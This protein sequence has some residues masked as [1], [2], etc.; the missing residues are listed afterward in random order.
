MKSV[1]LGEQIDLV[2]QD[3][4]RREQAGDISPN[5]LRAIENSYR[6][7]KDYWGQ[8]STKEVTKEKWDEFQDWF[9]KL[10]PNGSHFNS[11]K[12]FTVLIGKLHE[13]GF[14][15]QKIL[16][17]DRFARRE[18]NQRRKKK[19]WVF[20]S[21]EIKALDDACIDLKERAQLRL[22]YLMGFRISDV[23]QLTWDRIILTGKHAYVEFNG[24]D[25]KAGTIARCPLPPDLLEMILELPKN[26]KWVFPQSRNSDRHIKT[27]Q[28]D[29]LAIRRRSGVVRG[30]FHSL[31]HFCLSRD[32]KN[33]KLTT[34]QVCKMRRVSLAVA[35]EHYVHVSDDDMGLM[36]EET[37]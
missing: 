3:Y 34:A 15:K 4:R 23:C 10:N 21:E 17:K 35:H 1:N 36:I 29:F 5:S 25:D 24:S 26:S 13:Q 14:L 27:Q 2:I 28:I 32:F 19:N 11:K 37:K 9:E 30:T 16:V 18:K 12:Y 33:P 20:T 8:L 6:I 22:G 31:R 7:L